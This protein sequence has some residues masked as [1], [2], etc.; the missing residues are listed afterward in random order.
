MTTYKMHGAYPRL[1]NAVRVKALR[2]GQLVGA[3]PLTL[4]RART[5]RAGARS[6]PRTNKAAVCELPS[7]VMVSTWRTAYECS[8]CSVTSVSP[9]GRTRRAST[10][11]PEVPQAE[12]TR[13]FRQGLAGGAVHRTSWRQPRSR[14]R[15]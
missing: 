11:I 8:D 12:V 5:T 9:L 1:S 13:P 3:V 4:G 15:S 2:K 6:A 7:Y 10:A 14:T